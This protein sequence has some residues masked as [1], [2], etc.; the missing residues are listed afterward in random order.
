M[1]RLLVS[2]TLALALVGVFASSAGA[3]PKVVGP[4]VVECSASRTVAD[5]GWDNFSTYRIRSLMNREYTPGGA[6]C[7]EWISQVW[8]NA[9]S[10]TTFSYVVTCIYRGNG[11]C[12]YPGGAPNGVTVPG[13]NTYIYNA[14]SWMDLNAVE[15]GCDWEARATV[16]TFTLFSPV[17]CA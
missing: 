7:N 2:L 10:T 8:V 17:V 4:K 16:N 5:S 11:Q 15:P 14:A 12:F 9:F 6:D 1:K 13:G 3:T